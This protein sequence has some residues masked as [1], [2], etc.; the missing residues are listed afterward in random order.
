MKKFLF[1]LLFFS[2]TLLPPLFP[3]CLES[4]H[5]CSPLL[6][7]KIKKAKKGDYLIIKRG[8]TLTLMHIFDFKENLLSIE[9]VTIPEY[10][11]K[12]LKMSWKDWLSK[13]APRHSS[14]LGSEINT[15]D[16]AITEL[17]SFSKQAHLQI[18]QTDSFISMLLKLP[19]KKISEKER[20]KIGP[21]PEPGKKDQR[22]LWE[23]SLVFEGEAIQDASFDAYRALWPSDGSE[24][25]NK[26]IEIFLPTDEGPYPSYL[27]YW[28]HIE[29]YLLNAR[30]RI[31]DSGQNLDSPQSE[32][33]RRPPS[34]LSYAYTENGDIQFILDLPLFYRDFSLLAAKENASLSSAVNLPYQIS[35]GENMS[36]FRCLLLK[37]T[38]Q[39]QLSLGENYFF[40][41]S[42]KNNP[43][44]MVQTQKP[45]VIK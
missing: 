15:E 23:P 14:W 2:N 11:F 42:P 6:L 24:L 7:E 40:Y 19:F 21:P 36:Q 25:S 32:I 28:L 44:L 9:E 20:K 35:P 22:D 27:P 17:Y 5:S 31:I 3:N 10:K 41:I 26:T 45:V 4:K 34:L 33:P 43:Y 18:Q 37:E 13:G 8:K 16:G 29:N 12:P 1:L 30:F 38:L 39:H